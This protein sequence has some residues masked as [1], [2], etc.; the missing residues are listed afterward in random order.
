MPIN[1]E[2]MEIKIQEAIKEI[3]RGTS[4]IIDDVRL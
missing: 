1:R 2:V 3:T 4:E